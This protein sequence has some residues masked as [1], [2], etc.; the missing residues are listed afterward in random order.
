MK[1]CKY[2]EIQIIIGYRYSVTGIF[3]YDYYEGNNKICGI[4]S[5]VMPNSSVSIYGNGNRWASDFEDCTI[6]PGLLR[7]VRDANTDC[8]IAKIVYK[9]TGEYEIN[10]T[11]YV[12]C[13]NDKYSFVRNE[14]LIAKITRRNTEPQI[15]PDDLT[16]DHEIYFQAELYSELEAELKMLLLSFPMLRFAL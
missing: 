6:Y 7:E 2:Q 10:D 12:Y 1:K 11:V 4:S 14:E 3:G 8:Q 9:D 13:G 15:M 16:E 5:I